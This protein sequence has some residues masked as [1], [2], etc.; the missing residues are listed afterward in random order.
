MVGV[1]YTGAGD[2]Q[3]PEAVEV[4][5]V[6]GYET[7]GLYDQALAELEPDARANMRQLQADFSTLS[8]RPETFTNA[9]FSNMTAEEL[10]AFYSRMGGFEFRRK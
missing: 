5:G 4:D 10:A 9:K 6:R 2:F 1:R 7:I 8:R 3:M